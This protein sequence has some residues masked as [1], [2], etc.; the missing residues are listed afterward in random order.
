MTQ[1][2]P[3]QSLSLEND[4]SR[5][6]GHLYTRLDPTPLPDPRLVS[7]NPKVAEMLGLDPCSLD[8]ELLAGLLGGHQLPQGAQP[9]AM[10]YAGHQFGIYNP[11]L[12]DG[13]GLLLGEQPVNGELWDWHLKG[14]GQTPYSRMGDGR[15]VLRSSL[16]EYL[17]GEALTHLGIPSTRALALGV[18][19]QKILRERVEPGATILRISRCHVR[20]GHFEHL[21]YTR[22]HDDLKL[23]ADYCLQRWYPECL[24]AENPYLAMFRAISKRSAEMVAG[25]IAYGFLHGVMNTDNMSI[26]GETFDHGPFAFI[27]RWKE[28][29]VYNHTDQE[30]RYAFE[31]QPYVIHWNLSALGQALT[32]LID[33]ELLKEEL[34]R[35][36]G[37]YNKAY[38]QRMR[39][40]LGL[41]LSDP[42]DKD[43][44]RRWRALLNSNQADFNPLYRA[45]SEAQTEE[46]GKPVI[47]RLDV[48]AWQTMLADWLPEY[49]ARLAL[50][51]RSSAD[52]KQAMLQTNPSYILRTHVTT[53]LVDQAEEGNF[54]PIHDWLKILQNPYEEHAGFEEWKRAPDSKRLI[55]LSCSS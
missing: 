53:H 13:R 2:Q 40:R 12:G 30:S 8:P 55:M 7:A 34:N 5:L 15:A 54:Q 46:D 21:F 44:I 24:E 35:Y 52:R 11:Q 14:A 29:A 3:L 37:Y 17:I 1:W 48:A 27:D 43:F 42:G 28:D 41:A 38:L 49:E 4:F 33:V 18:T 22:Q 23:L 39:D 45:L 50:E 47:N 31:Q 19:S 9:L 16:R 36:S 26:L 6:P 51:S 32:P 20:F 25:W 10:K